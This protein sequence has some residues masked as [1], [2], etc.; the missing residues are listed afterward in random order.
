MMTLT[1]TFGRMHNYLRISLTHR[2]NFKCI[3]CM[4]EKH[5]ASPAKQ[6]MTADEIESFTKIFYN[7]GVNKIRLTGGEPLIRKDAGEIIERLSKYPIE[8]TIT[9]N[10][11][12]LHRFI[13]SLKKSGIHTINISLDTLKADRFLA[14]TKTNL[15]S[16]IWSNIQQ[17]LAEGF[18]VKINM[19]VMRGTNDDEIIDFVRLT[20]NTR[21]EIRFIEYM[22]FEGNLWE[23]EKVMAQSEVL[24]LIATKYKFNSMPRSIHDTAEHYQVEGHLGNF[25]TISTMSHPFCSG[26]N[27]IRLTADGKMKNCLFSENETDLLTAY[28]K[29]E[30]ILPLIKQS[31]SKKALAT[32]GQFH[33][34]FAGINTAKIHNRS[35]VEIGG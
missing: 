2:C 3:Y 8:L 29:G 19:V 11:A 6:L 12:Q 7:L 26:C 21:L 17:I 23:S 31:I 35:M 13:S 9:T 30:D 14:I 27:R 33:G 25:A 1:D 32:G 34:D 24:K 15:F 20:K 22:P 16:Q 28:R 10:G 18:K 4:P 5:V